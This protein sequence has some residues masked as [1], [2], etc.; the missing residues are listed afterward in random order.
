MSDKYDASRIEE[1]LRDD[2]LA[3]AERITGKRA[4]D[5]D[6]V[7]LGL[8][9][10]MRKA[11]A[12]RHMLTA[13]GDT[14]F[15]STLS[16]YVEVIERIG[17]EL[18]LLDRFADHRDPAVTNSYRIYYRKPSC[19]LTFDTYG[20]EESVNGGKVHYCW[21]PNDNVD[22]WR[23][24][25][26]GHTTKDGIWVGDHDC[27][28]AIVHNL[29]RLEKNGTFVE[30]WPER[31]FM[32]LINYSESHEIHQRLKDDWKASTA[33]CDAVT[34]GRMGRIPQHVRDALGLDALYLTPAPEPSNE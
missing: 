8:M 9:L 34:N 31:Q 23:I 21:R 1:V 30:P 33:E 2:P 6:T 15:S 25:S 26:S 18:V 5:H 17:F 28:E 27:R 12:A 29:T 22:D 19:L 24:T 11:E 13:N 7:M 10:H 32:W 14:H 4:D 20:G 16:E 3:N